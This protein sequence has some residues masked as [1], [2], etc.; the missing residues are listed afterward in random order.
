MR[1]KC[2]TVFSV[3]ILYTNSEGNPT[4]T[5]ELIFPYEKRLESIFNWIETRSQVNKT[6]CR[7]EVFTPAFYSTWERKFHGG[8]KVA[9]ITRTDDGV[10]HKH[11]FY[12][13]K[14]QLSERN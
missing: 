12:P 5:G 2:N 6:W 9:L 10:V 7:I 4:Y 14:E 11:V 3:H 1:D 13:Y 8:E